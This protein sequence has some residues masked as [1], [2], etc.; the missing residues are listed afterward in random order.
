MDPQQPVEPKKL[1][2][3]ERE[4]MQ[5]AKRRRIRAEESLDREI[6]EKKKLLRE[7]RLLL[8]RRERRIARLEK[9]VAIARHEQP[10]NAPAPPQLSAEPQP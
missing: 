8:E 7:A 2:G 1:T 3:R 6:K 9:R 4:A 5:K 10:G